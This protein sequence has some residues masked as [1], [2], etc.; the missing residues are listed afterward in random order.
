MTSENFDLTFDSAGLS[1]FEEIK[2]MEHFPLP[3][4][5]AM[6]LIRLTQRESTSLAVLAHALKADP[7]FSVRLIKVANGASSNEHRPVVSLRDAVSVLGVPAIR[8]LALGF[9]LLSNYRSGTCRNFDHAR[10][11]SRSLARAVAL[12][13]LTGA[14]QRSEAEEAFSV[15]LLARVGELALAEVFAEQYADL[16]ERRRQESSCRLIDLEQEAFGISH[17]VLTASMMRDCGLPEDCV[18]SAQMFEDCEEQR[19]EEGSTQFVTR[20]LLALADHVADICVAP[21]A[22]WRAL[23]PRLFQLGSRLGFDAAALIAICDRASHEWREWGPALEVDTG[24]MPRFENVPAEPPAPLK[25]ATEPAAVSSAHS[26]QGISILVVGD[27]ERVRM[28][29]C[30][31]LTAAGHSVF[32]AANGRQGLAMAIELRPQIMLVDLQAGEMDGIELTHSLRQFMVGRSIYILLLT[33]THLLT[34]TDDDEK[35]VEAFEAGVDD[36]LTL[37][38]KPRVLAARLRAGQ[39]VVRLQEELAHDQEEIRRISAELSVTNQRLQEV[40]MTD[41]L[42]GCPNRRAAMDRIQQEWAMSTRSQRPL[43]CMIINIDN[44]KQVNDSHGHDAGDA[45][46]KLVAGALKD[47]MRA[48]DVLARTGGDEFMVLCPDTTLEAATACAERIR[49]VVET[50]PIVSD[51]H[52]VRGSVSVGVA[53]RDGATADPNALIRLADHSVY[54][55]K[56]RR[57]AVATVQSVSTASVRSA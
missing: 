44:F 45:V 29:L 23:M 49:A 27:Q 40:G 53:V 26:G 28:Q 5:A 34:G 9:S 50:L 17:N 54:L 47:E 10:F 32:E 31:V 41:M 37:P 25:K 14:T 46:L 48:Q 55:A 7:V 4:G 39:R 51:A 21:Q 43:A 18:E 13:L 57:N 1:R 6:A 11:W 8:A 33:G 42:T 15:G 24:P 52:D 38:I 20:Y 2:G 36:F 56:R 19:L 16:L 22:G 12:Q 3:K 30:G 35:L